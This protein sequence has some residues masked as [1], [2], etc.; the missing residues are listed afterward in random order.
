[1]AGVVGALA[2]MYLM[3]LVDGNNPKQMRH[4]KRTIMRTA[5][6]GASRLVSAY[7]MGKN[8]VQNGVSFMRQ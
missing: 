1:M 2:G 4:R 3:S 7:D 8:A 5:R 6:S